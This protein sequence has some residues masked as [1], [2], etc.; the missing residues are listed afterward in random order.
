MINEDLEARIGKVLSVILLIILYLFVLLIFNTYYYISNLDRFNTHTL[1]NLTAE[2]IQIVKNQS[3]IKIPEDAQN[4]ILTSKYELVNVRIEQVYYLYFE[5][6]QNPS[7]STIQLKDNYRGN[8]S[9]PLLDL[10]L[11]EG[12]RPDGRS[13]IVLLDIILTAIVVSVYIV[14]RQVK[15]RK[16]V[17]VDS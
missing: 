15:K 10:V 16:K 11:S 12:Y 4:I 17:E 3:H 14:V 13:E 7:G 8:G 2:Q 9:S 6:Q 5:T 1:K